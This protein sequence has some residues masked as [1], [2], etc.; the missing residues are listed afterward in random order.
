MSATL[1]QSGNDENRWIYFGQLFKCV[2]FLIPNTDDPIHK[3]PREFGDD[4]EGTDEQ[5]TEKPFLKFVL[6][7]NIST[8]NKRYHNINEWCQ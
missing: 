2:D 7:P 1:F 6:N 4:E 8:A 3:V 5:N